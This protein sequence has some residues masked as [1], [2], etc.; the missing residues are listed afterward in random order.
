M[1]QIFL[2]RSIKSKIDI[3]FT[4]TLAV[5]TLTVLQLVGVQYYTVKTRVT[6]RSGE[7]IESPVS[8]LG[9]DHDWSICHLWHWCCN[10]LD[11]NLALA[12]CDIGCTPCPFLTIVWRVLVVHLSTFQTRNG[13]IIPCIVQLLPLFIE[14][15]ISN[16]R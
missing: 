9:H 6:I 1:W 2:F 14:Q 13:T 15:D 4:Q 8:G 16:K 10:V 11:L 3:I 5:H 7:A 12:T